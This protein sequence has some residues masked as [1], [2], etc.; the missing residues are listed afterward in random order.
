MSNSYDW[1]NNKKTYKKAH[2]MTFWKK[3][4]KCEKLHFPKRSKKEKLA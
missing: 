1:E 3:K 4:Q 2:Y